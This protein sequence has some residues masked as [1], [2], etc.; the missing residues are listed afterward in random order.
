MQVT[1]VRDHVTHATLG[2]AKTRDFGISDSADFF[3]ILSSALYKNPKFAFIRETLCNAWDA[4]I[5]AGRTDT[6]M[7]ISLDK[8]KLVIRDFGKGISDEMIQPIYGI[9]GGSTKSHD[10]KQT[11]GFGLGCKAPFA[12]V[13]HFEV[14]S[15]HG[16]IRNIY[17]MSKSSADAKGKPGIIPIADFPTTETGLKVTIQIKQGDQSTLEQYIRR[18]VANGGMKATL[19]GNEVKTLPWDAMKQDFLIAKYKFLDDESHSILLRYGNVV[20]PI[21]KSELSYECKVM[22]KEIEDFLYYIGKSKVY[23]NR[24][25]GRTDFKIVFQAPAHSISVMPSREGLSMVEHTTNT[26]KE[27]FELFIS[28]ITHKLRDACALLVEVSLSTA[29]QKKNK[30]FFLKM[31]QE[32]MGLDKDN[33]LED[34]VGVDIDGLS[35]QYASR[36]YPHFD[37]LWERDQQSRLKHLWNEDWLDK[38]LLASLMKHYHFSKRKASSVHRYQS[39]WFQR[40]MVRRLYGHASQHEMIDPSRLFVANHTNRDRIAGMDGMYKLSDAPQGDPLSYL[41]HLRKIFVMSFTKN[42][43]TERMQRNP[44]F[45]A[46]Q[47]D[48]SKP[49]EKMGPF[50]VYH[51]HRSEKRLEVGRKFMNELK[52]KGWDVMDFTQDQPWENGKVTTLE[53]EMEER[54]RQNAQRAAKRAAAPKIEKVGGYAR[55]DMLTNKTDTISWVRVLFGDGQKAGGRIEEP[56]FYINAPG[57]RDREKDQIPGYS[58][59]T[60]RL[61]SSILGSKGAVAV[62]HHDVKRLTKANVPIL[63]DWAP[64]EIER[65]IK[66]SP[67]IKEYWAFDMARVI[68]TEKEIDF[69]TKTVMKLVYSVPQ[70][71]AKFG[72]IDNRTRIDRKIMRLHEAWNFREKDHKAKDGI[73]E[74]LN[75]IKLK[76]AGT[77]LMT[78]CKG[79]VLLSLMD[80]EKVSEVMMKPEGNPSREEAFSLLIR[81]LK[82]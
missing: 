50:I 16:G 8:D 46:W 53:A 31:P 3:N 38:G 60:S 58:P 18:V 64:G 68:A 39:D 5:D 1:S 22:F 20:Y 70:L 80:I 75:N 49:I 48:S 76:V 59:A 51:C 77:K 57:I 11:G 25:G 66:A 61:I 34:N 44:R 7:E 37:G 33:Y 30:E 55:L 52:A 40:V 19:N 21:E 4:H 32:L 10:G 35:K 45:Y 43:V 73:E 78:R 12:Y 17:N 69:V 29:I 2:G 56:E 6:A 74:Y 41:P 72:V 81:A 36:A 62:N 15:M 9:Y 54:R 28:R 42:D 47:T 63:E 67:T 79:N 65:L 71:M 14:Q 27:M 24:Y 82:G 23:H 13:E 26:I